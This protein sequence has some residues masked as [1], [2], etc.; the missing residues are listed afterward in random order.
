[1]HSF[2]NF[3]HN[4]FCSFLQSPPISLFFFYNTSFVL[5]SLLFWLLARLSLHFR[6]A[7][8][9]NQFDI[10]LFIRCFHNFCFYRFWQLPHHVVN[11]ESSPFLHLRLYILCIRSFAMPPQMRNFLFIHFII[12]FICFIFRSFGWRCNVQLVCDSSDEVVGQKQNH[13]K[14]S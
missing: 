7:H 11:F 14:I 10:H 4:F 5:S 2:M 12:I 8:S 9:P 1:M 3:F 13:N 6:I